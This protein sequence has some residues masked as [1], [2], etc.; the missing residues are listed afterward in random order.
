MTTENMD[1][2][3]VQQE[4]EEID[5]RTRDDLARRKELVKRRTALVLE[6]L[7]DA[8]IG[9]MSFAEGGYQFSLEQTRKPQVELIHDLYPEVFGYLT[10]QAYPSLDISTPALTKVLKDIGFMQEEITHILN[11][12]TRDNE[13]YAKARK[14]LETAYKE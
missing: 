6:G 8:P 3:A 12:V 13:P 14:N 10:G 4:I 9:V 5:A 7:R 11:R 2:L 1:L